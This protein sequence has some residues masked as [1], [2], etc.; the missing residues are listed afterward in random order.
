MFVYFVFNLTLSWELSTAQEPIYGT[1]IA[2][3]A[4]CCYCDQGAIFAD[5]SLERRGYVPGEAI[6]VHARIRNSTQ[7][8]V[9]SQVQ[10]CQVI[11]HQFH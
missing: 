4:F 1:D 6:R 2:T 7:Y 8:L 3:D 5:L 10:L 11:G 9:N